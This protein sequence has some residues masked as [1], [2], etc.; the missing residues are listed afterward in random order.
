MPRYSQDLCGQ[1]CRPTSFKTSQPLPKRNEDGL[2]KVFA[3]SF[4]KFAR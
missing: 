2:G 3:G 4:D 1:G